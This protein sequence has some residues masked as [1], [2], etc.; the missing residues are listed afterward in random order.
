MHGNRQLGVIGWGYLI[1]Q[2]RSGAG[3]EAEA[4]AAAA[5]VPVEYV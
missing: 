3:A 4:E 5:A 1:H 2:E